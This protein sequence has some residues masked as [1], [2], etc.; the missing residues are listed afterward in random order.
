MRMLRHEVLLRLGNK[1]LKRKSV[2]KAVEGV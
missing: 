2:E 1:L